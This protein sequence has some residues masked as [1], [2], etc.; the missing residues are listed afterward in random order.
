MKLF[1]L[2][3][4][5]QTHFNEM[6]YRLFVLYILNIKIYMLKIVHQKDK[7]HFYENN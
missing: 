5:Y 1:F 4:C 2:S 7:L 3:S 6:S